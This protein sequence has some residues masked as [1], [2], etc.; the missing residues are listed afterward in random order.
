MSFT[1][2]QHYIKLDE[3]VNLAFIPARGGSKRIPR[4]NLRDFHG[5]PLLRRAIEG[6][7]DASCFDEI[8]VS[9]DDEEIATRAESFGASVVFRPMALADD[10]ATTTE[11]LRHFIS[12]RAALEQD[13]SA[14]VTKVYPATYFGG[15]IIRDFVNSAEKNLLVPHVT[16]GRFESNP[17]RALKNAPDGLLELVDSRLSKVRSQDLE[18]FFFDAGKLYLASVGLW[19]ETE[20]VLDG[21]VVGFELPRWASVDLDTIEDWQCAEALFEAQFH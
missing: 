7:I 14:A 6:C 13:S 19:L 5:Q 17:S 11:V 4:K 20:N 2:K 9:T 8:I 21:P 3:K 1:L 10:F 12:S 18:S 15:S 16:V